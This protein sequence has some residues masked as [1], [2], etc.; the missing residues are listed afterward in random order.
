VS[1]VTIQVLGRSVR[2]PVGLTIMKAMEFNGFKLLRGVGCRGGFCGACA[3][4]YRKPG[5]WRL[6]EEGMQLEG[7][8]FVPAN[9]ASYCLAETI[10]STGT[11]LLAAHYPE[12]G[13]CVACNACT[14]ACPQGL[15]VMDFVQL[16]L[17]DD[18]EGV[19][20]SSFDCLQCGLCAIRCPAEIAHHH[21]AQLARRAHARHEIEPSRELTRRVD[22]IAAGHFRGELDRLTTASRAELTALYA[23]RTIEQ[24]A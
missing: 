8:P 11:T 4:L 20:R 2:V 1:D 7:L 18:L 10:P 14:K 5:E 17:R 6:V 13:R 22:E 24:A 15:E 12:L 19:A 23:A 9:R 16:A 3:M 21:V